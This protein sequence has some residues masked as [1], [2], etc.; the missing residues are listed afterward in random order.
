MSDA[1][2]GSSRFPLDESTPPGAGPVHPVGSCLAIACALIAALAGA[3]AR[4]ADTDEPAAAAAVAADAGEAGE[5][6]ATESDEADT[7]IPGDFE[8]EVTLV[9]DYIDR[10]ISNTDHKPAL[11]GGITYSIETG[12]GDTAAYAGF[13]GSSVDFDDGDEATVELDWFFGLSGTFPGTELGWD[14]GGA[15]YAYPGASRQLNYDYWEIPVVL[16]H[17]IWQNVTLSGSYY[18]SPEYF[19]DTGQAHY[20]NG[21]LSWEIPIEPVTLV[22]A[23]ATGHQWIADNTEAGIKDYQDWSVG[24]TVKYDMVNVGLD[25]TDTDLSK[26]ECYQGTNLCDPRV[27]LR[28]GATF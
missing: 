9:S 3:P 6:A 1:R 13:W 5:P 21:S 24:L 12:I 16:S 8:A 2:S 25:Y 22:L 7:G 20:V 19:G 17:P 11:Q 4:A 18:Y 10:G 15:Y 23:A 27:V 14:V 26:S 28:V